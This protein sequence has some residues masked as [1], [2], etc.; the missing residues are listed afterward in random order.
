MRAMLHDFTTFP[1]RLPFDDLD[2]DRL[3]DLRRACAQLH[4]RV[5]L[6]DDGRAFVTVTN[7]REAFY[8][9]STFALRIAFRQGGLADHPPDASNVIVKNSH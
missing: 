2:A 6:D 4:L 5:T 9:G 1:C 8:L 7:A 3:E